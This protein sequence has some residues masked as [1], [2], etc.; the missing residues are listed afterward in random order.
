MYNNYFHAQTLESSNQQLYSSVQKRSITP[1]MS[2]KKAAE[3]KSMLNRCNNQTL[4]HNF[5]LFMFY[6]LDENDNSNM[7][8]D[9][10]DI[11]WRTTKN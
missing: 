9:K 5:L 4:N 2:S 1:S 6:E 10:W 11:G 7:W 8:S 3:L